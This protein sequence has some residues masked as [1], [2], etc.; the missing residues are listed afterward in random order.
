MISTQNV[1]IIV[2]DIPDVFRIRH[3]QRDSVPRS[4]RYEPPHQKT[5]EPPLAQNRSSGGIAGPNS[6]PAGIHN[7]SPAD[8]HLPLIL[9]RF[10]LAGHKLASPRAVRLAPER[11]LDHL[12]GSPGSRSQLASA[13]RGCYFC[14]PQRPSLAR[15]SQI[16]VPEARVA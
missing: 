11:V 8:S 16:A 13:P 2:S 7:P 6:D 10:D 1:C 14:F 5:K 12:W 15:S 9:L 4:K 3:W